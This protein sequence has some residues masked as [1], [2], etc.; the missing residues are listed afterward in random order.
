M[1]NHP[2]PTAQMTPIERVM[3][4]IVV[5]ENG[6]WEWQ[7]ALTSGYG[8]VTYHGDHYS[9]HLFS[10]L[11][12]GNPY[13]LETLDH[14]CRYRACVNPG[15]LES[16]SNRENVMRGEAPSVKLHYANTCKQ[17]HSL[18]DAYQPPSRTGVECKTCMTLRNRATYERRLGGYYG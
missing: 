11:A 10:W 12:Y 14:L 2:S 1:S 8:R 9:A 3:R 18:S 4:D 7:M 16:V 13:P 17:G 6:C 15:H 5:L